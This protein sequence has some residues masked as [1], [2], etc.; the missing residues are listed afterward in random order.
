[1]KLRVTVW[2]PWQ[3]PE[4]ELATGVPGEDFGQHTRDINLADDQPVSALRVKRQ[5]GMAQMGVD[6]PGLVLGMVINP[7]L[8]R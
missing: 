5:A 4:T 8:H 3:Q 6:H 2:R 1:V 7:Q